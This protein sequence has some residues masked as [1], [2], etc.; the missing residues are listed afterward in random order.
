MFLKSIDSEEQHMP[1]NKFYKI[2]GVSL[3]LNILFIILNYCWGKDITTAIYH[4]RYD[5]QPHQWLGIF[6]LTITGLEFFAFRFKMEAIWFANKNNIVKA[7]QVFKN[8]P[9]ILR[10]MLSV[11]SILMLLGRFGL[12]VILTTT[13]IECIFLTK[14]LPLLVSIVLTFAPLIMSGYE[15]FIYFGN[16]ISY[17]TSRSKIPAFIAKIKKPLYIY[18]IWQILY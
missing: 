2:F 8:M 11:L 12:P 17:Q 10:F 15:L 13:A 6:I 18:I 5:A 1:S 9:G 14:K 7:N 16:I 4:V 3:L